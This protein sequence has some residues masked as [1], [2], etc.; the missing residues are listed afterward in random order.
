MDGQVDKAIAEEQ[1]AMTYL[2]LELSKAQNQRNNNSLFR[3]I[4][5]Y[6]STQSR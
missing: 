4:S 3:R 1:I 2:M 5:T 6:V